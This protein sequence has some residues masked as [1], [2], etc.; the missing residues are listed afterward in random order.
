MASRVWTTDEKKALAA[1]VFPLIEMQNHYG[2]K[3]DKKIVMR[4]W[5]LKLAGRFT[6]DQIIHALDVYTDHNDDFPTPAD[7]IKILNPEKPRITEAQ[8][9]Q[10][11]KEQERNNFPK[12]SP[13]YMVIQEYHRQEYKK[14]DDH[15]IKCDKLLEIA[16]ASV[17]PVVKEPK[18]EIGHDNVQS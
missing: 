17:K 3:M 16:K 7:I 12:F 1:I 9:V 11:C 8:F 2:K 6:V 15:A 10:A 4:G 18:K 13:A 14:Q 5:E